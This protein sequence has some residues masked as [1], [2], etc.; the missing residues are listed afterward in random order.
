LKTDRGSILNFICSTLVTVFAI[1]AIFFMQL[2]GLPVQRVSF[3]HKACYGDATLGSRQEIIAPDCAK[4][5]DFG[6]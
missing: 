1:F 3:T 4:Q 5:R 2:W 6:S